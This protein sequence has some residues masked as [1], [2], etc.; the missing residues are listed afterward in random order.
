[1]LYIPVYNVNWAVKALTITY[2]NCYSRPMQDT[3]FYVAF[4]VYRG[5]G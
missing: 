4:Y 5:M 1:M 2:Y 3:F